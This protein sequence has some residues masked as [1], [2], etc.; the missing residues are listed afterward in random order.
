MEAGGRIR[1][2]PMCG[3]PV[4]IRPAFG[5]KRPI[6]PSCGYIHFSDPKVAAAVL[7]EHQHQILLVRR[8]NMPEQGKW[9]LPAGFV[10]EGEDPRHAARRECLEETGL[11][12]KIGA[13][14][15]VLYGQEHPR[16]ASIVIAYYGE[17][18]GGNMQAMDDA[19]VAAFFSPNAL[20][21]LAF[22]ATRQLVQRWR[23][24]LAG[25]PPAAA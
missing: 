5:A 19:D 24:G 20:P 2:C 22:E 4:Q 15:D 16:G 12:V 1:F 14:I 13:L 11:L 3:A 18:E 6:C 25:E 10:D 21:L 17:I 8:V 9:S 7:V 23:T